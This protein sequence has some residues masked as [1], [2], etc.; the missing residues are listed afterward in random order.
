MSPTLTAATRRRTGDAT[1]RPL[2][3]IHANAWDAAT[4]APLI[5]HTTNTLTEPMRI[6]ADLA[7]VRENGYAVDD[8]EFLRGVRCVAVPVR[9]A[10]NKVVAAVAMSASDKR[11]SFSEMI[12]CLPAMRRAADALTAT[13]DW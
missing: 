1:T 4:H 7:L 12:E 6:A 5:A 2:V 3:T 8:G 10:E 13:I 9:N 11:V